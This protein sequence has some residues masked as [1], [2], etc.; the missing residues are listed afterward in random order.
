[1]DETVT[2]TAIIIDPNVNEKAAIKST[3]RRP[4][5]SFKYAD[6]IALIIAPTSVIL[7]I[8]S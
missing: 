7:T 1:M 3:I 2:L 4:N 8:T 5:L 6:D